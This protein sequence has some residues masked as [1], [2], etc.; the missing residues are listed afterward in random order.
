MKKILLI[1]ALT[2]AL[3]GCQTVSDVVPA[4]Q[5]TYL[6][7]TKALGG[8]TSDAEVS[9]L[10]IKRANEFCG[11]QEKQMELVNMSNSGTQGWTPQQSQILFKCAASTK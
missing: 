1:S 8:L 2:L 3:F 6:V 10:S 9:A 11:S 4:G 5:D 7:G